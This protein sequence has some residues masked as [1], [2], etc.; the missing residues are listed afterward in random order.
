[1]FYIYG[2]MFY[3]CCY[4][5][6]IWFYVSYV[7]VCFYMVVGKTEDFGFRISYL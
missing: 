1:M 6:Y 7:V 5:L 4:V 2:S 3:V